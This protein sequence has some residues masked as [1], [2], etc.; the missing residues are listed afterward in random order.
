MA[1]RVFILP[2]LLFNAGG[3]GQANAF[4]SR[5]L[6]RAAPIGISAASMSKDS[7]AVVMTGTPLP[8]NRGVVPAEDASGAM[9]LQREGTVAQQGLKTRATCATD[10]PA[11]VV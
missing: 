8:G 10:T 2:V 4:R 9:P 3:A 1:A 7:V 5:T 6:S 11:A